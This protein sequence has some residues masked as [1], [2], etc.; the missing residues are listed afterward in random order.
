MY[1]RPSP[2][3]SPCPRPRPSLRCMAVCLRRTL[4]TLGTTFA[5]FGEGALAGEQRTR[6][7]EAVCA[8]AHAGALEARLTV[9][10][11][12]ERLAVLVLLA[13]TETGCRIDDRRF[14]HILKIFKSHDDKSA[15]RL[16]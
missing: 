9:R 7:R 12:L 16:F 14:V 1:D 3:P 2:R 4:R 5:H 13:V 15:K 10:V 11:R 6:L 8:A